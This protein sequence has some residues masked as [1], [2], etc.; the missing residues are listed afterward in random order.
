MKATPERLNNREIARYWET[1]EDECGLSVD[2]AEAHERCWCCGYKGKLQH[3]H[4]VPESRGGAYAADNL[5]L[6]C[7]RCHREAP[8][9]A[10]SRYM[11]IWLRSHASTFYDFSIWAR[12]AIEFRI[13][14]G[15]L[16]FSEIPP[17]QVQ[18]CLVRAKEI[19]ELDLV[20]VH[21]G[22]GRKN[23]A[24]LACLFARI[25]EAISGKHPEP[26]K[27]S[28]L[29]DEGLFPFLRSGNKV[30]QPP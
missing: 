19:F 29:D 24:T 12:A 8:N 15:R 3:A 6:L 7:K 21:W 4:I 13:M 10:D 22:E 11:W 14:F 25:E 18:Q 23:A 26:R 1:R 30:E 2:W 5:I 28:W 27:G 16:P 9:I 17:D 20:V